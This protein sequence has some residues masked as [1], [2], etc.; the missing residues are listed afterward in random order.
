MGS[1]AALGK[2]SLVEGFALG[3]A[4]VYLVSDPDE[5]RRAW[6]S[7]PP[8]VSV[9]ILTRDAAETIEAELQSTEWPMRVVIE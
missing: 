1:V 8:D 4:L 3:G 9:V 7:L 2:G 6:M 5:T